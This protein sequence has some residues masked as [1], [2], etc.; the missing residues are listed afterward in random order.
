FSSSSAAQPPSALSRSHFPNPQFPTLPPSA[1]TS[2]P[3]A[4]SLPISLPSPCC[5]ASPLC[6]VVARFNEIVMQHAVLCY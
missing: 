2:Q 3:P 1:A 4:V 6:E 5:P